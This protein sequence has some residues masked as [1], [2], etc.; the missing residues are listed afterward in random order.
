LAASSSGYAALAGLLFRAPGTWLGFWTINRIG[1]QTLLI[2]LTAMPS[3]AI[4][5]EATAAQLGWVVPE[6]LSA[7]E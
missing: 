4:A 6:S 2:A 5:L 3:F 7:A 1:V